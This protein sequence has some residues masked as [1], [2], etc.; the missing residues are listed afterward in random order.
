DFD[1]EHVGTS[2]ESLGYAAVPGE[3]VVIGAGAIGLEM[4]SVWSRLGAKVKVL[5]YLDR[6]LPGMDGQIAKEAQ[7]VLTKQG[8]EF[9]LG[10]KVIG[11]R[12]DGDRRVVQIEGGQEVA[13]DRVLVAVGRVP[14]TDGLGLEDVGV[15]QDE[16]GF[17][18]VDPHF[19]TN[20]EGIFA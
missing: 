13:C 1:G 8:L 15:H 3:L 18:K 12:K 9:Q 17:V 7:R 2:T 4:G 20:V 16:R 11:V 14:N 10:V 19:K 5:E 6:I